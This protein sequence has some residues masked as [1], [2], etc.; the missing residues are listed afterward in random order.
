MKYATVVWLVWQVMCC[1]TFLRAQSGARNEYVVPLKLYDDHLIVVQ[2]GL[3]GL[4]GR[5]LVLDTGAYPTVIDQEV[6]RKLKLRV[7]R[8]Q[9][10]V[11][12]RD[13][14]AGSTV[15]PRVEVG[16]LLVG[17]LP[18]IVEDLSGLSAKVGMRVDGLIGLDVLSHMNFRIDYERKEVAFG[19]RPRLRFSAPLEPRESM[20]LLALEVNGHAV[21]LLIDT[22]AARTV[23][24]TQRVPWL[25][26]GGSLRRDFNNVGGKFALREVKADA[27]ALGGAAIAPEGI[28]LSDATNMSSY[29]FDGFM[30]TRAAHFR[31]VA[32]DF[33]GGIFSWEPGTVAAPSRSGTNTDL[34]ATAHR[35]DSTGPAAGFA[36][37]MHG[38]GVTGAAV[39]VD[40]GQPGLPALRP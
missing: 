40:L 11:L 9:M 19:A 3:G 20:A 8:E 35:E 25:K 6:A 27:V 24:F 21:H 7:Q 28:F 16:P 39:G 26:T 12:E 31:Q 32:F 15:V 18:V 14:P 10:H 37:D 36:P 13:L 1:T 29:P 38:V 2:G 34:S 23:L 33:E 22:G 17:N 5:N 4:P 30:S